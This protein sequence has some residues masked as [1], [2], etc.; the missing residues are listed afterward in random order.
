MEVWPPAHHQNGRAAPRTHRSLGMVRRLCLRAGP[1]AAAWHPGTAHRFVAPRNSTCPKQRILEAT[2]H[3]PRCR[4]P[5]N[6]KR[7]PGNT[8]AITRRRRAWPTPRAIG[9]TPKCR[10]PRTSCSL[11]SGS[12][13]HRLRLM[14]RRKSNT[15]DGSLPAR[16][17]LRHHRRL[18]NGH[19]GRTMACRSRPCGRKHTRTRGHRHRVPTAGTPRLP[20]PIP[21]V[22][23]TWRHRADHHRRCPWVP[24]KA[25]RRRRPP[26]RLCARPT[27]GLQRR[28]RPGPG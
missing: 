6:R 1:S 25:G 12:P 18:T 4:P 11:L 5:G 27:L 17:C 10:T 28:R 23:P 7:Q 19:R 13:G 15:R 24:C 22:R 20:P 16:H 3:C 26:Q 14:S 21:N 8:A 9:G 2:I